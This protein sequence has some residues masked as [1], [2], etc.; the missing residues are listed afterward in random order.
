MRGAR[1]WRSADVGCGEQELREFFGCLVTKSRM[2]PFFVVICHP[3]ADYGADIGHVSKHRLV[4]QLLAHATVEAFHKTILHWFTWG[5]QCHSTFCSKTLVGDYTPKLDYSVNISK[6]LRE[7]HSMQ[8]VFKKCAGSRIK[9][10]VVRHA[11]Y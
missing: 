1:L 6:N 11:A 10:R 3:Y 4:E 9:T 2:W 8:W 5:D 7:G